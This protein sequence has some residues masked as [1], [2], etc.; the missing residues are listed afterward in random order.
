MSSSFLKYGWIYKNSLGQCFDKLFLNAASCQ[1]AESNEFVRTTIEPKLEVQKTN[2]PYSSIKT[3]GFVSWA[4]LGHFYKLAKLFLDL[5][6]SN[7]LTKT[8]FLY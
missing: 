2:K 7:N 1:M 3:S 6:I 5:S 8:N 4:L